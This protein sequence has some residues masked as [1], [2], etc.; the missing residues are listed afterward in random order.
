MVSCSIQP[1]GHKRHGPKIGAVPLLWRG[2]LGLHLTQYVH[3]EAYLHTKWHPNPSDR[4]AT[5]HQRHSTN[6]QTMVRQHR[7]NRFTN[8][9]PKINTTALSRTMV[10]G[11]SSNV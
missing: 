4:L 6:R 11:D 7:A 9:R 1:F 2:E 10:N 5:I 3:A 8:G